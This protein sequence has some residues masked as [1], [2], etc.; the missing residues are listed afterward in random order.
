MT[1][2]GFQVQE[3]GHSN[4]HK[5]A[6]EVMGALMDDGQVTLEE[7]TA[8]MTGELDS[9]DLYEAARIA[10]AVLSRPDAEAQHNGFITLSK[11]EDVCQEYE[12]F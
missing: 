8:L 1:A 4:K 5:E 11:L 9:Q 10:F 12:V 3:K 6:V 2:L 7:F